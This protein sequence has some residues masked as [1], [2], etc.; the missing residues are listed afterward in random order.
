MEALIQLL[1][2]P[3]ERKAHQYRLGVEKLK[4]AQIKRLKKLH[5]LFLTQHCVFITKQKA[6]VQVHIIL[7]IWSP[8]GDMLHMAHMAEVKQHE[9]FRHLETPHWYYNPLIIKRHLCSLEFSKVTVKQSSPCVI[10]H[11][12]NNPTHG[13]FLLHFSMPNTSADLQY[14]EFMIGWLFKFKSV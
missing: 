14:Q 13:F 2:L 9:H 7:R 10:W 1:Y 3:A 11:L 6:V 5:L 12:I 4:A 8:F